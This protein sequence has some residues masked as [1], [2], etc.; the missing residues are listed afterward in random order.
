MAPTTTLYD[1]TI[2]TLV[3]IATTGNKLL[4]KAEAYAQ[5]K[6]IPVTDLL[7]AR[8]A[9]DMWPLS[10]QVSVISAMSHKALARLV[11]DAGPEPKMQPLSPEEARSYLSST[12]Q[13]LKG[14]QREAV[15]GKED[16]AGPSSLGPF[17]LEMTGTDYVQG[18]ILPNC[19][20]HLSMIYAILRMKGLS[21]GKMDYLAE[22]LG[23][24]PTAQITKLR[25]QQ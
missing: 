7:D 6:G 5:E 8:L 17:Q 19:Y 15:D 16:K 11:G 1:L 20:F 23:E 2:P 3:K 24:G 4:Q 9:E 13:Q 21:V 18:V 22:F 10:Q 25:Q 12:L 14:V